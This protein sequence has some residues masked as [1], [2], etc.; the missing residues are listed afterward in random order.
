MRIAVTSPSF[1]RNE[2]LRKEISGIFSEVTLNESG[3]KLQGRSLTDFVRGAD[4][5]I[6]GLETIDETV[7]KE[8]PKLKII[9]KHGVGLDNIDCECCQKN[10]IA[11]GWTPGVNRLSVAEM[12]LAF[13]I[14]LCRNIFVTSMQLK[15]GLWNKNG[16]VNLSDKTVGIIGVGNIGKEL[17]RLLKPFNCRILVNDIIDQADYY[18]ENGLIEQ[19]KED[20]YKHAD[21]VTIHVPLTDL[22]RYMVNRTMFALMK[23]TAFFI[24]TARAAIVNTG[25]LRRALAER[26]IAG[27]AVDVYDE[28]PPDNKDLLGLPNLVCTPHIG[29]NSE[30]SV[31]A[32]GRSAIDHL[33]RFFGTESSR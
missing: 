12:S 8:C 17:I 5:I 2:H 20:I 32:M 13:M 7:I 9:S 21:I 15:G 26:M 10:N 19:P 29:G 4:G 23:K 28:E 6:V 14:M 18:R 31:L 25:D 1:S 27:A 33:K 16:G 11:I 22:T 24:N 30:E 3:I